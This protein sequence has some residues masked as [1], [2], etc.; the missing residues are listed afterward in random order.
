M[1]VMMD[2]RDSSGSDDSAVWNQAVYKYE[3][4]FFETT[5]HS[6][7]MDL[8]VKTVFEEEKTPDKPSVEELDKARSI[9]QKIVREL[10]G[11]S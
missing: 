2:L 6:D 4:H 3:A 1:P 10:R 11:I 7:W 9:A 8:Q 5:P